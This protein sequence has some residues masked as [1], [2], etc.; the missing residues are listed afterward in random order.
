MAHLS[1][2]QECYDRALPL[3]RSFNSAM[4][5]VDDVVTWETMLS[6]ISVAGVFRT[7]RSWALA[8]QP[9]PQI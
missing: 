8:I 4:H 7:F 9:Q 5:V 1:D 2:N 6:T 3:I